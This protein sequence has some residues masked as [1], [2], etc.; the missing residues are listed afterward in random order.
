MWSSQT[1]ETAVPSRRMPDGA[2]VESA[3]RR[4]TGKR[5]DTV[6]KLS[7]ATLDVLREVGYQD[8]TLQAVAAQAGLARATAYTYFSSKEHLVAD[9]YWRRLAGAH[10]GDDKSTTPLNRVISVL[11]G[12]ALIVADEPQLAH[13][14]TVTMNSADPDVELLRLQIARFIHKLI[15]ESVGDT[16]DGET[17]VLLEL[18]YTGAMVRAGVGGMSYRDVADQLE[19]AAR[20]IL[21]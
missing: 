12:L 2:T 13:A 16:A 11:R 5:A 4:F 19:A 1:G 17:V 18:V 14:V 3:R 7:R 8:L 15:A 21:A 6:L 9:V 10:L 20:R